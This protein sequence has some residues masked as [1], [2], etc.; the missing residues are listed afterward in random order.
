MTMN[1]TVATQQNETYASSNPAKK[2]KKNRAGSNTKAMNPEKK[3]KAIQAF[4]GIPEIVEQ[5][6]GT[7]L[8]YE[9]KTVHNGKEGE[10]RLVFIGDHFVVKRNTKTGMKIEDSYNKKYQL[11][12]SHGLCMVFAAMIMKND[13]KQ[14]T[15][16]SS[17]ST[18][19]ENTKQALIWS[20]KHLLR[21]DNPINPRDVFEF[22]VDGNKFSISIIQ[23]CKQLRSM[24]RKEKYTSAIAFQKP[25][26]YRRHKFKQLK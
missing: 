14:L 18:L 4:L 2:V 15:P 25:Y 3:I 9:K 20:A 26:N 17:E 23:A 21:K 10:S 1:E 7:R 16:G 24:A 5:L 12:N 22:T 6:A 13:T 8:H 19:Q 11:R